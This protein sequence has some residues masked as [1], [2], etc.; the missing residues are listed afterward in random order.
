MKSIRPATIACLLIISVVLFFRL[1]SCISSSINESTS[2]KK[3]L[4][5]NGPLVKKAV[6]GQH[7]KD[8]QSINLT[9]EH[10]RNGNE[11]VKAG[12]VEQATEE[13]R[14]AYS[15]DRGSRSVSGLKLAMTYEKQGLF[16]DGIKLL[17]QMKVNGELS[18]TGVEMA[19][20]IISRLLAAKAE[21]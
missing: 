3:S 18:S 10:I 19:N 4:E 14:K 12:N 20:Q 9:W 2:N 15:L 16:D 8:V 11:F 21:Q 7:E 6:L 13:F 5:T 1:P 17:N